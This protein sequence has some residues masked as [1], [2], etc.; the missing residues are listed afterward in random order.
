MEVEIPFF[1]ILALVTR[2]NLLI[3]ASLYKLST[4]EPVAG[5]GDK[6]VVIRLFLHPG[7]G[8]QK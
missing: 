1:S 8:S 3:S 5:G 4:W 7:L 6:E 2:N